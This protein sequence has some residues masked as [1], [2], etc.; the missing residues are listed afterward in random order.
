[1]HVGWRGR[2]LYLLT[3]VVGAVLTS[4]AASTG[5]TRLNG[6]GI[7]DVNGADG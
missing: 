1:M 4:F 5:N 2:E 6:H 3:K 7:T